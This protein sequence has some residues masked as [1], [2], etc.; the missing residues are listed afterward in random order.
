MTTTQTPN[1]RKKALTALAAI[2]VV[3]GIG[4]AVWEWQ[5]GIRYES[6]DNAY[7]QGNVIQITPQIGGTVVWLCS[8]YAD[9]VTGTTISVDGGWTAM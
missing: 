6:T 3:A 5:V 8:P 2:V 7:V 4:W 9:Q 1:P